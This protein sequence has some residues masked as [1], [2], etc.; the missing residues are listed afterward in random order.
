MNPHFIFNTLNTIQRFYLSND[1]DIGNNLLNKFGRLMRMILDNTNESFI[2]IEDE[3]DFLKN[4]LE[5]EQ[6]RY[7]NK[8]SYQIS[9]DERIDSSITLI[10]SMIIQPFV[11]NAII[12]GFPSL[13]VKG[14]LRVDFSLKNNSIKIIIDDNGIGRNSS[15]KKNHVSRGINLIRE[16]LNVLNNKNKTHYSLE[17][18]DKENSGGTLI[19]IIL[20]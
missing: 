12:H 13:K 11:E 5:I 18:I 7:N 4:Y 20:K 6:L 19:E 16:R 15:L 17:I 2:T 9:I 3:V 1:I 10:P 8:F 14:L